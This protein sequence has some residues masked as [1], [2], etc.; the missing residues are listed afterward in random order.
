MIRL[1]SKPSGHWTSLSFDLLLY[2][3]FNSFGLC[4]SHEVILV[5]SLRPY[6]L[7]INPFRVALSSNIISLLTSKERYRSNFSYSL[8]KY[9]KNKSFS[10]LE[11]ILIIRVELIHVHS[12]IYLLISRNEHNVHHSLAK[13]RSFF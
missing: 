13:Q 9:Y 4:I 1:L 12:F 11:L 7:L 3:L 2:W 10:L 5:Y 6:V 8:T